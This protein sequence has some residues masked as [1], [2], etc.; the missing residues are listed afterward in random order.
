MKS[1]IVVPTYN[2]AE[3]IDPLVRA[4]MDLS[5]GLSVLVVD[6]NSPDGTG[7]VVKKLQL[8][9]P[10]LH[11]LERAGKNGL[12]AAYGA[13]FA[14]ALQRDFDAIVEMDADFSHDPKDLP[15][16][17]NALKDS[18]VA[19]GSRYVPGGKVTGWSLDRQII[20]RGGNVYAQLILRLPYKDLTGGFTAWSRRA[21][22]QVVVP[23]IQSK[24]YAFQVELK[25]RAHRAGMKLV[26]VP[27]HFRNRIVGESKMSGNI[28]WEAA[29][30]V[31]QMRQ[32]AG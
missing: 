29:L 23:A 26:E 30:R 19:I 3:N 8:E 15:R 5:A 20:S 14:W 11:L 12:A 1:L 27:I 7:R 31:L 4:I 9:Y 18:D 6:D 24:G 13:G 17:L 22:E 28:V 21:L 2:E 32:S 25:N 16:L 10:E